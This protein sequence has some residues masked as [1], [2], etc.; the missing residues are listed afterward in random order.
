MYTHGQILVFTIQ[1]R[2]NLDIT[3]LTENSIMENISN[4]LQEASIILTQKPYKIVHE[5]KITG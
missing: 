3:T 2:S 5:I 1:E 4:W